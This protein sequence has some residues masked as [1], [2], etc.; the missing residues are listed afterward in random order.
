MMQ[1]R[2]V[3]NLRRKVVHLAVWDGDQL[4]SDERCLL[5]RMKKR[6]VIE[7]DP[8]AERLAGFV[9]RGYRL[10]ARCFAEEGRR[11][12]KWLDRLAEG[13]VWVQGARESDA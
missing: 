4:L 12:E 11:Q 3:L 10:C 7:A 1:S 8:D 9:G 5:A 2:Y 13:H 6:E